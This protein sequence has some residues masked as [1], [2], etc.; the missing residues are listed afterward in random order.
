MIKVRE[1]TTFVKLPPHL[2]KEITGGCQCAF[3]KSHPNK[4]PTW[5]VLA[6]DGKTSWT[7]HYPE[8]GTEG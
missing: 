3:C 7:V 6:T 8:L 1:G 2:Q 4:T 5:D